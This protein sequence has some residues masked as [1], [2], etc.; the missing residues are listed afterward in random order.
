MEQMAKQI[1]EI[2]AALFGV[3]G[4]GGLHRRMDD[5]E[6]RMDKSEERADKMDRAQTWALGAASG[7]S[8]GLTLAG[9]KLLGL[10]K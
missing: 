9:G 4:H 7:L 6:E 2:H 10:L 1:G 5:V 3:E 8:A